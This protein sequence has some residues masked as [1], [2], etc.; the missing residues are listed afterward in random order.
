VIGKNY[1]NLTTNIRPGKHYL[2]S[3]VKSKNVFIGGFY[4]DKLFLLLLKEIYMVLMKLG[5][6]DRHKLL[7]YYLTSHVNS[8]NVFI[9]V[10]YQDYLFSTVSER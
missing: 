1:F 10:L 6:G 5:S 4:Q 2:T 8:K 3:Y 7:Q 9:R